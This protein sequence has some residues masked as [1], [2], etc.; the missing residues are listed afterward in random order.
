L[1]AKVVEATSATHAALLMRINYA[2]SFQPYLPEVH[3]HLPVSEHLLQMAELT[4]EQKLKRLH[5][6]APY[7]RSAG[8]D[9]QP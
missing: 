1:A 7:V 6:V 8:S 3:S 4:W 9:R 2:E 5:F